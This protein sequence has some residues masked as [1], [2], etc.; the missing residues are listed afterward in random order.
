MPMWL[1]PPRHNDYCM[2]TEK[3]RELQPNAALTSDD[4]IYVAEILV[5]AKLSEPFSGKKHEN[6][7]NTVTKEKE[8]VV[9]KVQENE[10][11]TNCK[12]L[13]KVE[14]KEPEKVIAKEPKEKQENIDKIIEEKV[15][16]V[17]EKDMVVD[18]TEKE[19]TGEIKQER[20][21]FPRGR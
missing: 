5:I 10:K 9:A 3:D 13:P 16:Q 11:T 4:C 20:S 21:R 19:M 8:E 12:V 7:E 6:V 15:M 18:V 1:R 14:P 17:E 2:I